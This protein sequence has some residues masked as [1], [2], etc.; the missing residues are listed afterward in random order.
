MRMRP[1]MSPC[2]RALLAVHCCVGLSIGQ[3]SGTAGQILIVEGIADAHVWATDDASRLLARNGGRPE[4]EVN[5]NLWTAVQLNPSL[6]VYALGVVHN[7][8]PLGD[9]GLAGD[10]EL[11]QVTIRYTRSQALVAEAG[12]IESPLGTYASRRLPNRNPLIGAPDG[13]PPSYPWGFKL[14]GS[15]NKL[16]Y[17]GGLVSLPA[18]NTRYVPEPDH[19]LRPVLG[20]GVTPTPHLRVGTSMTW[21]P[22]LGDGV[23]PTLPSGSTTSDFHQWILG[24]DARFST[25]HLDTHAELAF[26][27]YEVPT[28][29]AS[30]NGYTYYLETTYQFSPRLYASSRF[31]QN[32][33]PFVRP[34]EGASWIAA[35]RNFYNGEVGV[36]YRIGRGSI[37]KGSYRRD[38]WPVD[39]TS[40]IPFENGH[41][42]ALQFSHQFDAVSLVRP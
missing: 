30:K 40:Q 8:T 13:Y 41:A 3:P 2:R 22:Y 34:R 33:Y 4:L 19:A 14:S 25:G 16:D 12:L 23:L 27:G 24:F 6:F 11:T 28:H 32:N 18:V 31:E 21:G 17:R 35:T 36:G 1:I 29:E 42:V 9:S 15:W 20:L 10:A 26:S 39:P 5:L 7:T 37:I 38:Y